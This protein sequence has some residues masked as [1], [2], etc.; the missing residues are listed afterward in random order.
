MAWYDELAGMFGGGGQPPMMDQGGY[1]AGAPSGGQP[2]D[3]YSGAYGTPPFVPQ[4]GGGQQSQRNPFTPQMPGFEFEDMAYMNPMNMGMG[5]GDG[6]PFEPNRAANIANAIAIFAGQI[7]GAPEVVQMAQE[8]LKQ[9]QAIAYQQQVRQAQMMQYEQLRQAA[10]QKQ[11]HESTQE[12]EKRAMSMMSAGSS[13]PTFNPGG[14]SAAAQNPLDQEAMQAMLPGS[15]PESRGFYDDA[16]TTQRNE[17]AKNQADLSGRQQV[18]ESGIVP[19]EIGQKGEAELGVKLEE[20]AALDPLD[21][22]KAGAE[23]G[24]RIDAE[25]R[26]LPQLAQIAE[27]KRD[28]NSG[29]GGD[30]P[31]AGPLG[32]FQKRFDSILTDWDQRWRT[33]VGEADMKESDPGVVEAKRQEFM[34]ANARPEIAR[35]ASRAIDLVLRGPMKPD[36]SIPELYSLVEVLNPGPKPEYAGEDNAS[37]AQK[38]ASWASAYKDYEAAKQRIMTV[39]ASYGQ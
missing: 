11:Q 17:E 38:L 7:G 26:R 3:P 39:L 19:Q 31:Y 29:D 24:A 10:M 32:R 4:Q 30:R 1:A 27:A 13:Y 34:E 23:T 6:N 37:F 5:P 15:G 12:A 21:V 18:L 33:A 9:R 8:Q 16:Y 14:I 2:P 22:R 25:A 35:E 28:P 36:K 20:R